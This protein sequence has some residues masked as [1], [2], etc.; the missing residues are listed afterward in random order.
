MSLLELCSLLEE[1]ELA[2]RRAFIRSFVIETKAT[3]DE[4]LLTYTVHSYQRGYPKRH[5]EFFIPY[6]QVEPGDDIGNF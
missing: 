1:S 3:G 5:R 6:A 4:V 2:E